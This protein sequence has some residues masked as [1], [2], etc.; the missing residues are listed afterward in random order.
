M[1]INDNPHNLVK[2]FDDPIDHNDVYHLQYSVFEPSTGQSLGATNFKGT[3][4]SII[5]K[6]IKAHRESSLMVARS[7]RKIQFVESQL[8]QATE[9]GTTPEMTPTSSQA[10]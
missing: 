6:L 4:F 5:G 7:R 10:Q 3:L 1:S 2:L 9:V 8:K